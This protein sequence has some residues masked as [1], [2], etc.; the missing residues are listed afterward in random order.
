MSKIKNYFEM[1]IANI[2][3]S[4][5]E[6]A[7]SFL[8]YYLLLSFIPLLLFISQTV[9]NLVPDMY[10]YL[11]NTIEN[12]PKEVHEILLPILDG[13]FKKTSSSLSI[14]AVITAIWL[15]SRGFLGLIKSLNKI[16]DVSTEN[17]FPFYEIVFSV[18]YTI[19]FTLL[20][21]ALLLFSVYNEKIIAIISN[22]T[23]QF[24]IISPISDFLIGSFSQIIP[25]L[26]AIV[27][28]I[29]F[30]RYGPSFERGKRISFLDSFLGALF[31]T[32]ALFALTAFYKFTSD[33]LSTNPTI[34]GSMANIFA[35]L[36]WLLTICSIIIYGAVF[37]KTNIDYR[38]SEEV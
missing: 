34:Y 9:I 37:I 6:F 20:I 5:I 8:A 31:T 22:F 24:Q 2:K 4:E 32:I 15:G 23:D 7:S 26:I 18:V 19:A 1:F 30:Y 16:F 36:V 13:I 35:V 21:A 33:S 14:V 27:I 29:F 28:F 3:K 17:K 38:N 10:D 12:L 11:L 25:F